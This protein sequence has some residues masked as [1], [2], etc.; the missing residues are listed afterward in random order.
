ML[1]DLVDGLFTRPAGVEFKCK[2]CPIGSGEN[3]SASDAQYGRG[4]FGRELE[5]QRA[6]WTHHYSKPV[7]L[8]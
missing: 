5:T 2:V 1:C 6:L 7:V 8:E 4:R 3:S